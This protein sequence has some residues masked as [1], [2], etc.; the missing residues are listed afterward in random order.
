MQTAN[1]TKKGFT[2]IELLVAITVIGILSAVVIPAFKKVVRNSRAT[3]FAHDIR[4]FAQAGA[5]YSLES[6]WWVPDT[7]TGEYPTELEGYVSK[8]K[9]DLGSSLGGEWDFESFDIG[10]YTSAVGVVDPTEGDEV[11]AIVDK[12]IDDG[13]LA[14]GLFQKLAANRYYYIIED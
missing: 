7:N 1:K 6:G 2:L 10:N 5:Q 8:Q 9:F 14:S 3:S 4:V 11:F 13:N 12:R